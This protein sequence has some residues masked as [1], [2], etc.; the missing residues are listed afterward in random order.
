MKLKIAMPA[1]TAIRKFATINGIY[2]AVL[3][4]TATYGAH[5]VE[6]HLSN[7]QCLLRGAEIGVP[8][9]IGAA[10]AFVAISKLIRNEW[11][12]DD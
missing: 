9:S 11:A 3:I 12:K 5:A 8:L 4:T 7:L 6:P 1:K 2:G 10:G